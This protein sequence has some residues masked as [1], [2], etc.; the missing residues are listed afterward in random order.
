MSAP[1]NLEP[2]NISYVKQKTVG[3]YEGQDCDLWYCWSE[4][5]P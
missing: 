4:L 1:L 3:F 2:E 5:S